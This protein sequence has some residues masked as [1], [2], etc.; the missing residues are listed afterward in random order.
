MNRKQLILLLVV[1]AVIGGAGLVL[2]NQHK[3]SWAV[4]EAK[5]GD[6]VLPN[7]QP[8]DVA[9]IHIKGGADLNIVR[10]KDV[11]RVKERGDYLANFGQISDLLI[12]LRDLKIVEAE[13]VGSSDLA[14]VNLDEPG[15]G[16][17]SGTLVEFKDGQGKVL[18]SL[19]LGKKHMRQQNESS[20]ARLVGGDPD[21]R[22]IL[23]PG[24]PKDVLLISDALN[25]LQ[26]NPRQWLNKDFFKVGKMK[27][28][29]LAST[30]A[31]NSWKLTRETE[32]SPWVLIDGK[33]G[34]VLDTK[35]I[36]PIVNA[37]NLPMFVDVASTN[38]SGNSGWDKP[39]VVTIET[40]DHFAYA[41]K[42][43]AKGGGEDSYRMTVAVTADI[44]MERVSGKDELPDEKKKLDKEFQDNNRKL[45][46][47]L[48]QE[49]AL[50]PWVYV[51]NS[52]IMDPMLHDRAQILQGNTEEKAADAGNMSTPSAATKQGSTPADSGWT[53]HVIK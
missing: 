37:L 10:E 13:T 44:P 4:H 45:Q 48:K 35:K 33:P 28:I 32:S 2:L 24:D 9:A 26:P 31:A 43:G 49:Q 50:A 53:P 30:N 18:A 52:W 40:F 14:R 36:S 11:W 25:S 3:E 12:K 5:M 6:K 21:G 7:F 22:Y 1:L 20:P 23:L 29:S 47:K 41:L 39:M 17:D 51:V 38:A 42:V 15:K 16:V 46:D 8:N 19:L 34:E 27:S